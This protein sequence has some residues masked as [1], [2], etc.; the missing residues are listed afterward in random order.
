MGC[1]CAA[2]H[3][4]ALTHVSGQPA[5]SAGPHTRLWSARGCC[6]ECRLSHTSPASAGLLHEYRPSHT[7]SASEG[8][9]PRGRPLH[10]SG[11]PA[12][13]TGPHTRLW[14]ARGCYLE[15]RSSHTSAASEGPLI[16]V[17]GQRGAPHARVRPVRGCCLE[18]T[19][20]SAANT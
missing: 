3:L 7:S 20:L 5:S 13:R 4:S 1:G 6:L 2:I 14:S 15:C 19:F 17:S 12:S 9:L 8:L 11:Q 16:H 18:C 10:V